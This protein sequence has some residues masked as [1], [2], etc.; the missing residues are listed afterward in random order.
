MKRYD[1]ALDAAQQAVALDPSLV[2]AYET[3]AQIYEEMGRPEEAAAARE[4][5]N[6]L[7]LATV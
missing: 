5:A 3:L 6:A 1:E 7:S 2:L 4:Q